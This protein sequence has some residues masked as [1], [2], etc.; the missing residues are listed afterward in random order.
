[1]RIFKW[2]KDSELKMIDDGLDAG[3]IEG[4]ID[5]D[6]KHFVELSEQLE[7]EILLRKN[8]IPWDGQR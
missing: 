1:V 7:A 2:F 6:D 8:L 4:L 5:S 3:V